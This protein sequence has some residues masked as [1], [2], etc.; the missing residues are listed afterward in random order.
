MEKESISAKY[1]SV[2]DELEHISKPISFK[3]F[4][5]I[6]KDLIDLTTLIENADLWSDNDRIDE[7]DTNSLKY[8][9]VFYEHGKFVDSNAVSAQF[10]NNENNNNSNKNDSMKRNTLRL[11]VLQISESMI[12]KFVS[13]VIINLKLIQENN[14][15]N[16]NEFKNIIKWI[17]TYSDLRQKEISNFGSKG[18]VKLNEL[19]KINFNNGDPIARRD[20]KINK[21]KIEKE[22]NLKIKILEDKETF[23]K[24]DDEIIRKIRIDQLILAVVDSV[25]ILESMSMEREML[26]NI[27]GNESDNDLQQ[28]NIDG[29]KLNIEDNEDSDLRKKKNVVNSFDKGYTDKLENFQR[30]NPI[31]SKEGKVLRPFTIVSSDQKKKELQSKVFGTGQ[32]L[33]TMTVEELVEQELQNGGMV[34]PQEPEPEVDEDD[35]KWQDKE[36]HRLREWDEFTDTHKKGSGNKMGNL[37]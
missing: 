3:Q 27:V 13:V 31:L 29:I 12:W 2:H 6:H 11:I 21:F 14:E 1:S 28:L 25:G 22:L 18:F 34:K 5:K 24:L 8:L 32:V 35:Y 19:E 26:T 36:T 20:M 7:I 4:Q 30:D 16:E 33:P 23:N 9:L 37:G 17:Y 15:I 10:N